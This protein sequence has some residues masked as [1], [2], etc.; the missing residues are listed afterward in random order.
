MKTWF[1]LGSLL[2]LS[3]SAFLE[4]NPSY[5]D[6]NGGCERGVTQCDLA[7]HSCVPLGSLGL[8]SVGTIMPETTR[9]SGGATMTLSGNNFRLGMKVVVNGD[10][11]N[12]ITPTMIS[13]T[14]MQ[15][16]MPA[17]P[18]LCGQVP[19]AVLDELGATGTGTATLRMKY[20]NLKLQSVL[21]TM[22]DTANHV[23]IGDLDGDDNADVLLGFAEGLPLGIYR[24]DG[25]LSLMPGSRFGSENSSYT[26]TLI[27][28]VSADGKPDIIARTKTSITPYEGTGNLGF[29]GG[30]DLSRTN[31][32]ITV[33][34]IDN[35]PGLELIVGLVD[36]MHQVDYWSYTTG[37]F[38]SGLSQDVGEVPSL[39][40][41]IV[42]GDFNDDGLVDIAIAS[43]GDSKVVYWLGSGST[44][45]GESKSFTV[46]GEPA[47]LQAVDVDGD[48]KQELIVATSD[49][50]R[51]ELVLAK[52][53]NNQ[54]EAMPFAPVDPNPL[55]MYVADF[56]CD[57]RGD[58]VL[59]HDGGEKE[60]RVYLNDGA[61]SFAM[62]PILVGMGEAGTDVAVGSLDRLVD[63]K[64]DVV[65]VANMLTMSVMTVFRNSSD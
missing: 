1:L 65:L 4:P 58:V 34:A 47:F 63:D 21:R 64:P 31:S 40:G 53:I 48:N 16:T 62:S 44:D 33:A 55:K 61:G 7:R 19:V 59:Y 18:G 30:A 54:F 50:T 20:G 52:L 28:D 42:S 51:G 57:G 38:Y 35:V 6:E 25:R 11:A 46:T 2:S 45:F 29:S 5:C 39:P 24:N 9:T 27:R 10:T 26:S 14:T 43:T 3:C 23:N 13:P 41:P 32:D 12:P 60:L 37:T 15:F 17:R 36:V 49:A 22:V 8:P 56:D